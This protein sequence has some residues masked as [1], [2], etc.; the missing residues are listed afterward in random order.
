[1]GPWIFTGYI[2]VFHS[3][4]GLGFRVLRV[5]AWALNMVPTLLCRVLRQRALNL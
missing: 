2:R 4:S 3:V 5:G 1:M